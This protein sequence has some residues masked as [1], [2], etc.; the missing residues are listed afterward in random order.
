MSRCA[1]GTGERSRAAV[2]RCF[3]ALLLLTLLREK[4]VVFANSI[5]DLL[6]IVFLELIFT[7]PTLSQ[8]FDATLNWLFIPKSVLQYTDSEVEGN[9]S[10]A[11]K[12]TNDGRFGASIFEHDFPDGDHPFRCTAFVAK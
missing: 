4:L 6:S 10:P 1:R 8:Q 12:R 5:L 7:E 11:I 2:A 3:Q 9:D